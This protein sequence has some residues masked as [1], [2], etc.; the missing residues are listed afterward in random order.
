MHCK[1]VYHERLFFIFDIRKSNESMYVQTGCSPLFLLFLLKLL[2]CGLPRR[3]CRMLRDTWF[4]TCDNV[5]RKQTITNYCFFIFDIRTSNESMY[6]QTG[7]SPV[8]VCSSW[9]CLH[10]GCT[11]VRTECFVIHGFARATI[12]FES[13]IVGRA[14]R[15]VWRILSPFQM[16]GGTHMSCRSS[17]K[18][19]RSSLQET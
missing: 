9:S 11:G 8:F 19:S 12:L 10:V 14:A 3:Q 4:R 16:T 2:T 1:G 13:K 17:L 7:C 15:G 18:V 6:V 5:F